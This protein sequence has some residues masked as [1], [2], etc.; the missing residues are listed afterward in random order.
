ME[1]STAAP[2]SYSPIHPST[3]P[4]PLLNAALHCTL[5]FQ[6][7]VSQMA[8]NMCGDQVND[9]ATACG[10]HGLRGRSLRFITM[11]YLVCAWENCQAQKRAAGYVGKGSEG[12]SRL[13][14]VHRWVL[15]PSP[16]KDRITDVCW[17]ESS[18]QS[19]AKRTPSP[20]L[21]HL[22]AICTGDKSQQPTGL[23][24]QLH[25]NE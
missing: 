15:V 20:A 24:L 16:V 4:V 12:Q 23:P 9:M 7:A 17:A 1:P 19:W 5:F 18:L 6:G 22:D 11:Q 25:Q 21:L 14:S 2:C 10:E 8:W 13:C 3:S